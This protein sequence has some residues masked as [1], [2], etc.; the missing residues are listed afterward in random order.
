MQ[1]IHAIQRYAKICVALI[2]MSCFYNNTAIPRE[3]IKVSGIGKK[4][5]E[6]NH[7][8]YKSVKA[9][10]L[11]NAIE[12]S[13]NKKLIIGIYP[14]KRSKNIYA[15]DFALMIFSQDANGASKNLSEKIDS[16]SFTIQSINYF[17]YLKSHGV[18]S[19]RIPNVYYVEISYS[20]IKAI[21]AI[22]FYFSVETQHMNYYL[23][24]AKAET[25]QN[26][27][28]SSGFDSTGKCPPCKLPIRFWDST[29]KCPPTCPIKALPY[30]LNVRN[31][32]NR[33][34]KIKS[35]K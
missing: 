17:N 16:A 19:E 23:L 1:P 8:I 21:D 32:I 10:A 29:G 27:V 30:A 14:V 13:K 24:S 15:N 22:G 31:E 4:Q 7:K 34:Y 5:T 25:T 28:Y 2:I 12:K 18:A 9:S 33:I 20:D 26:S 6:A 11:K 35:Y 3:T